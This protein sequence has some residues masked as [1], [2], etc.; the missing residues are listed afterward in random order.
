MCLE[1]SSNLGVKE[2]ICRTILENR[3]SIVCVQECIDPLALHDLCDELN[4]PR[5]R[6]VAEW[7]PNTRNWKYAISAGCADGQLNGLGFIY[8]A[9]RCDLIR[10]DCLDICLDDCVDKN[11]NS[12]A[13]PPSAYLASFRFSDWTCQV[14]N[15]Y[16]RYFDLTQADRIIE[17]VDQRLQQQHHDAVVQSVR[18]IFIVAGDF[19]DTTIEAEQPA[20]L[21]KHSRVT[22]SSPPPAATAA[23]DLDLKHLGLFNMIEPNSSSSAYRQRQDQ[24]KPP[25]GG[26]AKSTAPPTLAPQ[27][28]SSCNILCRERMPATRS[29]FREALYKTKTPLSIIGDLQQNGHGIDA[30]DATAADRL[31]GYWGIVSQGLCHMAIPHGFRWGGAV[32]P[33]CPVWVELYKCRERTAEPSRNASSTDVLNGGGGGGVVDGDE[34][35]TAAAK[36]QLYKRRGSISSNVSYH[37]MNGNTISGGGGRNHNQSM[38]VPGV[39]LTNGGGRGLND[40][41][42]S[43]FLDN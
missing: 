23:R 18:D 11:S 26:V 37:R 7:K 28:N 5:L 3:L 31:C 34:P 9:D 17:T 42:D 32:S 25:T 33:H 38:P 1:K 2:V 13:P 27:V 41:S 22:S 36:R 43:V 4:R 19:S 12:I 6:R 35:I 14:L 21:L 16:L 20:Y 8:N 10:E 40:S 15:T 39:L 30:T 24:T 29:A